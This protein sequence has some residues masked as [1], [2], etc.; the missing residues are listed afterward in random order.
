MSGAGNNATGGTIFTDNTVSGG[1]NDVVVSNL[2]VAQDMRVDGNFEVGTFTIDDL[3]VNNDLNVTDDLT[4]GGNAAADYLE[5]THDVNIH[6]SVFLDN[7]IVGNGLSYD[8]P[9]KRL[10]VDNATNVSDVLAG[11]ITITNGSVTNTLDHNHVT[12]ANTGSTRVG[13]IHLTTTDMEVGTTTNHPVDIIVN[14][15]AVATAQTNGCVRIGPGASM[16]DVAGARLILANETTPLSVF[17]QGTIGNEAVYPLE[18]M[19]K[20]RRFITAAGDGANTMYY[21]AYGGSGLDPDFVMCM[22]QGIGVGI[23]NGGINMPAITKQLHVFGDQE[24]TGTTAST[25]TTT[26][27][28][29]VAGG[30]GIAGTINAGA[31]ASAGVITTSSPNASTSTTTGALTVVGG[32]GVGGAVNAGSLATPGSISTS[33][34]TA[35]TSTTTGALTVAGGAG[36]A[37]TVNAGALA[38]SG[39][40]NTTSTT[41]STSTTTGALVV[42]GGA[43]IGGKINCG[44][45]KSFLNVEGIEV[46]AS[47]GIA[48]YPAQISF[49]VQSGVVSVA[50]I[51]ASGIQTVA[52][53]FPVSFA[54]TPS[55]TATP[56]ASSQITFA[57]VTSV[58]TL[59]CTLRIKNDSATTTATGVTCAWIAIG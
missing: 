14:N 49:R 23:C 22:R 6:G 18:I 41:A 4:V 11:S 44:D 42:A 46:K 37:G 16:G 9:T 21:G 27:A 34:T 59:G 47:Q 24:V 52:V 7:N 56:N 40:I 53:T 20:T 15:S 50:N 32:V 3:T 12:I 48:T 31:I 33:S 51:A 30:V 26:G 39:S 57:C 35:S 45:F 36:V 28:L 43:G 2:T 1:P 10:R 55:V 5:T 58:T 25:N 29:T 17:N 13:H 8:R 19:G 54:S 38:T